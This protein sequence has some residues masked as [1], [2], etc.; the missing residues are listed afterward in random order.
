M[1]FDISGYLGTPEAIDEKRY[2]VAIQHKPRF[3]RIEREGVAVSFRFEGPTNLMV[4][5]IKLGA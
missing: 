2:T 1:C 4:H 5:G 3:E